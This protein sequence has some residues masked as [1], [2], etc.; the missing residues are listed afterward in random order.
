MASSAVAAKLERYED[1]LNEKLK[2]EL[3]GVQDERD[4]VYE[5]IA[6]W[7]ACALCIDRSSAYRLLSLRV[8][9]PCPKLYAFLMCLR[10]RPPKPAAWNYATI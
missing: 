10:I 5:K 9:V 4:A 6:Q 8:H 1:W 3:Q 7:C 2:V